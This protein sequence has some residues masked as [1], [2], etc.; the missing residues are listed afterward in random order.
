V[1]LL[2]LMA[3]LPGWIFETDLWLRVQAA[4][5]DR[6]ARRGVLLAVLNS[7]LFVG[8]LPLFIGVAALVLFPP[9]GGAAPAAVGAEGE[10]IFAAL[11]A[12]WA[13]A[14]LSAVVAVGLVA[15]AMSTIDTCA[16]VMALSLAYDLLHVHERSGSGAASRLATAGSMGAL[17][18]FALNTESLWDLFYLSGGVLTTAVAFPVAAVF[19]PWARPDGVTW[20][21]RLGFAGTVAAYFL[22]SRDV[23]AGVEPAWLA[24]SGLGYILW[25]LAA[26]AVG[27]GVGA[28][29]GVFR[30]RNGENSESVR[31]RS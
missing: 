3:Y 22:E 28:A 10:A 31:P 20:S 27:Y 19:L 24:E 26:A 8:L 14:W 25:G 1:I 6:A 30:R 17:C 21:S 4:R 5:N 16:N 2:T 13:P 23:L 12:R 15:A 7:L 29:G 11:A 18:V 9:E